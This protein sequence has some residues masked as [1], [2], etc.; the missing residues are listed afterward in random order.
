VA[1]GGL[2]ASVFPYLAGLIAEVLPGTF[3]LS[4]A[5]PLM[6]GV[7]ALSRPRQH[8]KASALSSGLQ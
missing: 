2:G 3:I 7:F 8:S 6:L 5:A 4:L 1:A